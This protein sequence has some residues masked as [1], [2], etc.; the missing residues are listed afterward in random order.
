MSAANQAQI[1]LWDGRVGAKWAALHAALETMLA[2]VTLELTQR[3]GSVAGLRLLDIG[4]GNGKTCTIWLAG[5]AH[6]TGVDVSEAML[7]VATRRTAGM[8]DLIKAD[9]SIWRGEIPFDLAVSQFGLMFFA[10]PCAAFTNIAANVRLG[11]RLLFTCWRPVA[12]NQW[13]SL[14][15]SAIDDLVP[16]PSVPTVEPGVP[17]PGPFA[18]ADREQLSG[19][20]A[21]AGF[22]N[23]TITPLD[24]SVCL[25]TEGGAAAAADFSAQIGPA[26]TVIAEMEPEVKIAARERL[27]SAY[28]PFVREGRVDVGGAIWIVDATRQH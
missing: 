18:L 19:I 21:S 7:A 11:G 17:M 2:P 3:A 27:Q 13:V 28:A 9:A 23:I 26:A 5:G 8:A 4:C 22:S 1:D 12:E 15:M 16:Q 10:D 24:F 25:A 20:V 6:V 14:P